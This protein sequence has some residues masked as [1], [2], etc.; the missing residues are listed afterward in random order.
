MTEYNNKSIKDFQSITS[1]NT[2]KY[3]KLKLAY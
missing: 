3:I 1:E 2:E